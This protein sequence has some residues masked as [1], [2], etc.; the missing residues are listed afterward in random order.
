MVNERRGRWQF[1]I[2]LRYVLVIGVFLLTAAAV[3]HA[4]GPPPPSQTPL[5]PFCRNTEDLKRPG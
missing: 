4:Q 5:L 2:V 3:V 1:Y